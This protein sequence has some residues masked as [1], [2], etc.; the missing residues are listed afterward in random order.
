MLG[1]FLREP[2]L[3]KIRQK[4]IPEMLED[5][6]FEIAATHPVDEPLGAALL[7]ERRF[8]KNAPGAGVEFG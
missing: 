4:V 5:F 2:I 1:D 7:A 6:T 8:W 3:L